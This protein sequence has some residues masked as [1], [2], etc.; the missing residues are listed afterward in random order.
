MAPA[1]SV[2]LQR[3]GLDFR[4][5]KLGRANNHNR[6][7]SAGHDASVEQSCEDGKTGTM[8]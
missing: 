7:I 8:A 1:E 5:M 4:L 6:G 3:L 2:S